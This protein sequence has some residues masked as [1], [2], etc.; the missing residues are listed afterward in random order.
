[1]IFLPT[2][3]LQNL[4]ILPLKV[5]TLL[6]RLY[7]CDDLT[8]SPVTGLFEGFAFIQTSFFKLFLLD[9]KKDSLNPHN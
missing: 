4:L 8:E 9:S 3:T 2:A 7:W 6:S 5:S 1:M